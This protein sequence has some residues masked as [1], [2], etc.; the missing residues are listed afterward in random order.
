MYDQSYAAAQG[1]SAVEA[2]KGFGLSIVDFCDL[3][4]FM[5]YYFQR[6]SAG[7]HEEY[8]A[9]MARSEAK[10]KSKYPGVKAD[11]DISF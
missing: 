9:T 1:K 11:V 2:L 7:R 3:S 8:V 6:S 4:V 10:A 5:G